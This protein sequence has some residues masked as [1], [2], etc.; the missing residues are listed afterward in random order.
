MQLFD[1]TIVSIDS[2]L[3]IKLTK[4]TVKRSLSNIKRYSG[5]IPVD[6]TVLDHT[7]I[8]TLVLMAH[9]FDKEVLKQYFTHDFVECIVGDV[10]APIKKHL[11]NLTALEDKLTS[12]IRNNYN[13]ENKEHPVVKVLDSSI[14]WHECNF[15]KS[16]DPEF[17][18]DFSTWNNTEL[19]IDVH[20]LKYN[21][22]LEVV[23]DLLYSWLIEGKVFETQFNEYNLKIIE[24]AFTPKYT[25][26]HIY[27][28]Y[29]ETTQFK[30]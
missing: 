17:S 19:D 30:G 22:N 13:I 27:D 8:G 4:P 28:F 2:N 5:N 20:H 7:V 29:K 23:F 3:P 1:G 12:R 21:V 15:F 14:C 25:A 18:I 10:P 26:Q 16:Q 24:P 11:P 9:T 6:Y